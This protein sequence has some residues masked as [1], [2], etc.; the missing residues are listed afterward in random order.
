M[1]GNDRGGSSN[2]WRKRETA[3]LMFADLSTG[4][5]AGEQCVV[6]TD[7]QP[8]IPPDQAVELR[9]AFAECEGIRLPFHQ[10]H[11]LRF[12][13][14]GEVRP[15]AIKREETTHFPIALR[16]TQPIVSQHVVDL[17][18][19]HVRPLEHRLGFRRQAA[20]I[21]GDRCFLHG[22]VRRVHQQLAGDE[23]VLFD[24]EPL[25][26]IA[27]PLPQDLIENGVAVVERVEEPIGRRILLTEGPVVRRGQVELVVHGGP[28]RPGGHRGGSEQRYA[29]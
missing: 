22:Q 29:A 1:Y 6:E 21:R 17:P 18:V 28:L 27:R 16:F 26:N 25:G 15:R 20:V 7:L 9:V 13:A 24:F 14:E 19:Q 4:V 12:R 3:A 23:V 8:V 11:A 2:I 5:D 10:R